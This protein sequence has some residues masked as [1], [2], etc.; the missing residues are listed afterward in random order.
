MG[1][2]LVFVVEVCLFSRTQA[3]TSMQSI[4]AVSDK[5]LK[6]QRLFFIIKIYLSLTAAG[7]TKFERSKT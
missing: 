5:G 7:S 3:P 4:V 6:R 2:G 1:F